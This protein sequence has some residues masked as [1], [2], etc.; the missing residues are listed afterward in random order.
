MEKSDRCISSTGHGDCRYRITRHIA[1]AGISCGYAGV[2]KFGLL[3][4]AAFLPGLRRREDVFAGGPAREHAIAVC[5]RGKAGDRFARRARN[6]RACAAQPR[7]YIRPRARGWLRYS[8][9]LLH[10]EAVALGIELHSSFRAQRPDCGQDVGRVARNLRRLVCPPKSRICPAA[11]RALTFDGSD[12]P[13]QKSKARS[14]H[15]HTGARN[16]E[17]FMENKVDLG[18]VRAFS[19]KTCRCI[20][21]RDGTGYRIRSCARK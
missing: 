4:D 18:E 19:R 17:T 1:E 9:R 11:F 15:L 13:G 12:Q 21:P 16:G 8:D 20:I 14:A 5:C 3:G 2:A 10:G 6:G 7:P